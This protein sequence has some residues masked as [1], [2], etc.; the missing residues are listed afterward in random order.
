MITIE[1]FLKKFE[2]ELEDVEIGTLSPDTKFQEIDEW[3]SM[4]ALLVMAMI[5]KE[6]NKSIT[7]DD[8][9]KAQTIE[10]LYRAVI[11]N[12]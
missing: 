1:E 2:K 7:G 3:D 6:F 12:S 11:S 8:I 4:S 5:D 9:K 10:D